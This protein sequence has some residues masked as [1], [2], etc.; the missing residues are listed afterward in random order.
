MGFFEG[1]AQS[2]TRARERSEDAKQRKEELKL[3]YALPELMKRKNDWETQ[4]QKD[5]DLSLQAVTLAEQMGDPSFVQ[6]AQREL[7]SGVSYEEMQKRAAEGFY[8]KSKEPKNVV[9]PTAPPAGKMTP[10]ELMGLKP[11]AKPDYFNMPEGVKTPLPVP[12]EGL[13]GP[14]MPGDD[15]TGIRRVD[16]GLRD[17]ISEVSPELGDFYTNSPDTLRTED[18]AVGDTGW[19]I[20]RNAIQGKLTPG[21]DKIT[22]REGA[23]AALKAFSEGALNLSELDAQYLNNIAVGGKQATIPREVVQYPTTAL[24]ANQ[25]LADPGASERQKTIAKSA[26]DALEKQPKITSK[27]T[28]DEVAAFKAVPSVWDKMSPEQKQMGDGILKKE[29]EDTTRTS[30]G[31]NFKSVPEATARRMASSADPKTAAEGESWVKVYDDMAAA[32]NKKT[33]GMDWDKFIT[34]GMSEQAAKT[35]QAAIDANDPS[36]ENMTRSQM[37]MVKR[38]LGVANEEESKK[39]S[40]KEADRRAT[41]NTVAYMVEGDTVGDTVDIINGKYY[42]NG[43]EVPKEKVKEYSPKQ[44]DAIS[45]WDSSTKKTRDEMTS[46][47][48]T[49]KSIV[50][51]GNIVKDLKKEAFTNSALI[52][53][54]TAN[55]VEKELSALKSI[56]GGEGDIIGDQGQMASDIV[57]NKAREILSGSN[58]NL[59]DDATKVAIIKLD[60]AYKDLAN[61]GQEGNAVSKVDLENALKI[62]GNDKDKFLNY[63]KSRVEESKASLKD[64][65]QSLMSMTETQNLKSTLGGK[66]PKSIKDLEKKFGGVEGSQPTNKAPVEFDPKVTSE[67]EINSAVDKAPKGTVFI[68]GGQ[69][70]VKP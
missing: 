61:K 3:Q 25:M 17:K 20:K 37:D 13:E 19:T 23:I 70:F 68:I 45:N 32:K 10:S 64:K 1:F 65:Y 24:A 51:S 33:G 60:L 48:N 56:F 50:R 66:L 44:V 67:E 8:E 29:Q 9:V 41:S 6:V 18:E 28:A 53:L 54:G 43:V 16:A 69:K 42:S 7:K 49:A 22:E 38:R 15:T 57:Q 63:I 11:K 46:A 62:V 40:D 12:Q 4:K 31:D 14:V 59:Y 21:I 2:Y 27:T 36:T 5:K 34:P 26:L 35:A 30:S 55:T 52:V 47:E 39:Q 58:K